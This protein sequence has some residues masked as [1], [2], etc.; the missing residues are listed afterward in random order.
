MTAPTEDAQ[1][2]PV[3][4]RALAGAVALVSTLFAVVFLVSAAYGGFR[5][6]TPF[7]LISCTEP[8]RLLGLTAVLLL[9]WALVRRRGEGEWAAVPLSGQE[10]R[11]VPVFLL[12]LS[13]LLWLRFLYRSYERY[14]LGLSPQPLPFW[15]THL[16]FASVAP[17]CLFFWHDVRRRGGNLAAL[18]GAVMLA[19]APCAFYVSRT[20]AVAFLA[21]LAAWV[22]LTI[23]LRAAPS[24]KTACSWG[25]AA[26]AIVA[27]G[28]VV[29]H[30]TEWG[31]GGNRVWDQILGRAAPG[32]TGWLAVAGLTSLL[33]GMQTEGV[34]RAALVLAPFG[35]ALAGARGAGG[36]VGAVLLAPLAAVLSATG[37]A[38]LLDKTAAG[39]TAFGRN[40]LVLLLAGIL[41]GVA[42]Q[43]IDHGV[44]PPGTAEDGEV[45]QTRLQTIESQ[46]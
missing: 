28:V 37:V 15:Q 18:T 11:W 6:Q 43:G 16:I 32:L 20:T 33:L 19:F 22:V 2:T 29:L 12:I 45:E 25:L 36:E 31:W 13:G 8:S 27:V 38:F 1:E 14:L 39:R 5:V 24:K 41:L 44:W 9:A 23:L 35:L 17:A 34:L 3:A 10:A 4:G 30:R 26:L 21:A 40:I 42:K 7:G 46:E